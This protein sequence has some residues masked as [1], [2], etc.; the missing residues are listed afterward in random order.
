MSDM[1]RVGERVADGVGDEE[2]LVLHDPLGD[3]VEAV[4]DLDEVKSTVMVQDEEPVG[5]SVGDGDDDDDG[6]QV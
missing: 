3:A 2:S 5:E 4:C 1:D 6:L